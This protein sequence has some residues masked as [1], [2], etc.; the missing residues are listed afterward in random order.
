MFRELLLSDKRSL[1]IQEET[2]PE[3]RDWIV[4]LPGSGAELWDL[5]ED[6]KRALFN[7]RKAKANLL[8]INKPGIAWGGRVDKKIFEE[9]FRRDRR[10]QDYLEVMEPDG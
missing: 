4:F 10:V 2:Q 6:E 5:G 3:T 1:L 8:V 7:E 9:S